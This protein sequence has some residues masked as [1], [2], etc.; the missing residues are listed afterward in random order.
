MPVTSQFGREIEEDEVLRINL[1]LKMKASRY[2]AAGKKEW[3][4]P[5][6]HMKR[7][8]WAVLDNDWFLFPNLWKVPFTKAI[9]MGYMDGSSWAADEYGR[10]PGHPSSKM[11]RNG[12]TEN[13]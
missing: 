8:G 7:T 11:I 6:K 13:G 4:Y 5:E 12:V 10:H 2:V 1:I 9:S 3:L